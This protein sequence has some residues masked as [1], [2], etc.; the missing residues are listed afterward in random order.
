[1]A[2]SLLHYLPTLRLFFA[3]GVSNDY[4]LSEELV[5]FRT[6]EGPWRILDESDIEL[7]YRFNT[8]VG[9]WL[10]SYRL[11]ANPHRKRT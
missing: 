9:R 11:H 6:N 3:G 10:R 2:N 4:R 5:Q 7:H 1:L 8:E